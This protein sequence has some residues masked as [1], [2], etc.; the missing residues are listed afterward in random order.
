M[1]QPA[2]IRSG[3]KGDAQ[4]GGPGRRAQRP[5]WRTIVRW[6]RGP[7][8]A[9]L[10][11]SFG[12]GIANADTGQ[13]TPRGVATGQGLVPAAT[14]RTALVPVAACTIS[15]CDGWSGYRADGGY[16]QGVNAIF[17]VPTGFCTQGPS[18]SGPGTGYWA[19]LEG[20]TDW[21]PV[22]I[23][24]AGFQL[25]CQDGQ[26]TYGAW[27]AD[28]LGVATPV[29]EPVE[30]GDQVAVSIF[31]PGAGTCTQQLQDVTQNWDQTFSVDAPA[32]FSAN[33]AAVAA[34]STDGGITSTPVTVTDANVDITPIGQ[35][36]AQA[37]EQNPGLY[38]GAAAL[39]PSPLDPTG[40]NF[41]LAYDN[42]T[43]S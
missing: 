15:F 14:G 40:M 7:V 22:W 24:Q 18:E 1:D 6:G 42:S 38:D 8:I 4:A 33:T 2:S 35:V 31:C 43:G 36:G 34:E 5:G 39:V 28:Y 17:T 9:C 13:A 41:T 29:T 12:T 25:N 11:V 23:I 37:T 20:P 27:T 26:P 19:G 32:G 3:S 30:P 16:Y 10:L 21:A